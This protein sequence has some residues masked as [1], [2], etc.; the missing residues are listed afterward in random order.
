MQVGAVHARAY[1]M[2]KPV[3]VDGNTKTG[4]VGAHGLMKLTRGLPYWSCP[5]ASTACARDCYANFMP[6]LSFDKQADI[7]F[8]Y[9]YLALEAPEVLYAL[10]ARDLKV[11]QKVPVPVV[12]R[13]H[14]AGDFVSVDHVDVYRRLATEFPGTTFW[15][16]SHSWPLPGLG[17]HL[18]VLN[19]L[20]NVCIR[21]STDPS[22]VLA[23]GRAPVAHY[24]V[25]E[26]VVGYV[27]ATGAFMCPSELKRDDKG[28]VTRARIEN[29]VNRR[30]TSCIDCSRCWTVVDRPVV[31]T[32][33]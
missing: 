33:H 24:D 4:T 12:V 6:L 23:T 16:F 5:G 30:V 20:P 8:G 26:R 25:H 1:D 27:E 31:F 14:D 9:T 21:E 13:V 28:G 11:L 3:L 15:G 17:D 10:L 22:R 19:R 32:K 7:G 2:G 18:E 29:G